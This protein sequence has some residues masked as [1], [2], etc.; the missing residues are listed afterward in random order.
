MKRAS[1]ACLLRAIAS[2]AF[3]ADLP[4]AIESQRGIFLPLQ[5]LK[6]GRPTHQAGID[7]LLDQLV[8]SP[9]M[10]IAR[11]AAKCSSACLRCAGQ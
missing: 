1:V 11:R 10:S 8:P 6:V 3:C 4:H 2:T 9:S 5:S 7:Q